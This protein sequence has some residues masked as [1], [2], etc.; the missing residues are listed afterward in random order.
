[1]QSKLQFPSTCIYDLRTRINC[2]LLSP[3]F[4]RLKPGTVL[5]MKIEQKGMRVSNTVAL[6]QIARGSPSEYMLMMSARYFSE[7]AGADA[8][9]VR[10]ERIACR[11]KDTEDMQVYLQD[12]CRGVFCVG[13][14]NGSG[15]MFQNM[16]VMREMV[17][18]EMI[19]WNGAASLSPFRCADG[20]GDC[21]I[22]ALFFSIS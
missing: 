18:A 20:A 2:N 19:I 1:M 6:G 14:E 16:D 21:S 11:G 22:D 13:R 17:P 10:L 4:E 7:F 8:F 5:N 9:S 12:G 3:M 15:A